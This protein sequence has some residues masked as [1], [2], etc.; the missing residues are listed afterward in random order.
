MNEQKMEQQEDKNEL[1]ELAKQKVDQVK[2]EAIKQAKKRITQAVI[3]AIVASL[4]TI[5]MGIAIIIIVGLLIFGCKW[6][7]DKFSSDQISEVTKDLIGEYCTVTETGIKFNKEEVKKSI[8]E[9]LTSGEIDKEDLGF[10]S[11]DQIASMLLYDFLQAS[12]VP[13]L[14]YIIGSDLEARGIVH[15]YRDINK[16]GKIEQ[17]EE[18][19]FVRSRKI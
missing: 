9:R 15:F 18:M 16:D 3:H 2:N 17:E 8:E 13:Q 4:P 11:N 1:D 19:E 6:V 5:I 10:G 14:P 12:M 7:L